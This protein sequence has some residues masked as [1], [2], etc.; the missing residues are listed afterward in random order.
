M[1]Q[2]EEVKDAHDLTLGLEHGKSSMASWEIPEPKS[3]N[4]GFYMFLLGSWAF[5]GGLEENS[6][7]ARV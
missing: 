4:G 2:T 1:V 6:D 7:A 5:S 3:L